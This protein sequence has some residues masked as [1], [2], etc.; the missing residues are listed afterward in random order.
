MKI[1]KTFDELAKGIKTIVLPLFGGMALGYFASERKK[2][3][4]AFGKLVVDATED[5]PELYLD[6]DKD[7]LYELSK[8]KRIVWKVKKVRK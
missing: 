2:D 3:K 4:K 8:Q 1:P 7:K 5:T 6:I